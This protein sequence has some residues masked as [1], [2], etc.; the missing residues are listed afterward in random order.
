MSMSVYIVVKYRERY[1]L[2]CVVISLSCAF[3][4]ILVKHTT[5]VLAGIGFL[6]LTF[7]LI[8]YTFAATD[9]PL[10]VVYIQGPHWKSVTMMCHPLK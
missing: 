6:M 8:M 2:Y 5:P 10:N 1:L 7:D 3:Y 9:L 4:I